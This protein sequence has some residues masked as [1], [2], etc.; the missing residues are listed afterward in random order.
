MLMRNH[1]GDE[2]SPCET[3]RN[4]GGRREIRDKGGRGRKERTDPI[5]TQSGRAARSAHAREF[6]GGAVAS[7]EFLGGRAELKTRRLTVGLDCQRSM[8]R[9]RAPARHWPV[10]PQVSV[11]SRAWARCGARR[12]IAQVGRGSITLGPTRVFPIFFLFPYLVSFPFSFLEF[13]FNCELILILNV[14]IGHS[15]MEGV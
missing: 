8:S 12:Q 15:S 1:D 10:G 11:P 7:A 14:Q 2:L 9:A 6:C 13:N 4:N 5:C 3:R